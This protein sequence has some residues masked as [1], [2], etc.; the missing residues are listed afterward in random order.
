MYKEKNSKEIHHTQEK[1]V[2]AN[3]KR[4]NIHHIYQIL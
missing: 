3:L 1:I 4:P 2:K